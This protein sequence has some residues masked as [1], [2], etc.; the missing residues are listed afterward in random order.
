MAN[1]PQGSERTG[2]L[3]MITDLDLCQ[4]TIVKLAFLGW[5]SLIAL[6]VLIGGLAYALATFIF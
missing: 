1:H 2:G 3:N 5:A 4:R 6:I